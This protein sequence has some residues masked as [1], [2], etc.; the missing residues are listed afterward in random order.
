MSQWKGAAAKMKAVGAVKE[1]ID[2]YKVHKK[3]GWRAAG[4]VSAFAS[5]TNTTRRSARLSYSRPENAKKLEEDVKAKLEQKRKDGLGT[6][7]SMFAAKGGQKLTAKERIAARLGKKAPA[8]GS[9]GLTEM[10]AGN[11]VVEWEDEGE[12]EE[13]EEDEDE[14]MEEKST[15]RGAGSSR[16]ISKP[17]SQGSARSSGRKSQR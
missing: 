1:S 2:E 17:S 10:M 5:H 12:E 8:E 16:G 7:S 11:T 6:N 13:E 15:S 14:E 3:K 9:T 4:A